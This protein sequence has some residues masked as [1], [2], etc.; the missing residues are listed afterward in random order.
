[1]ATT[2]ISA[3]SATQH[4]S[5]SSDCSTTSLEFASS[6]DGRRSQALCQRLARKAGQM[7][8]QIL[9]VCWWKLREAEAVLT[10]RCQKLSGWKSWWKS[11]EILSSRKILTEDPTNIEKMFLENQN[12]ICRKPMQETGQ[13]SFQSLWDTQSCSWCQNLRA[14]LNLP[15]KVSARFSPNSTTFTHKVLNPSTFPL[16]P[17][18]F[19]EALWNPS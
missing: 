5:S 14:A 18:V 19:L 12:S 4:Y 17:L 8:W 13:I 1:M 15:L 11:S 6:C 9:P 10:E 16:I 3:N 2:Y 7:K